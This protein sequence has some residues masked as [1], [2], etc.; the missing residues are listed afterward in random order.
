MKR[1]FMNK[2]IG[3][4]IYPTL[5]VDWEAG[6]PRIPLFIIGKLRK[7]DLATYHFFKPDIHSQTQAGNNLL[8]EPGFDTTDLLVGASR[9]GDGFI[10]PW[11]LADGGKNSQTNGEDDGWHPQLIGA[12]NCRRLFG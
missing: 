10:D 12:S 11:P 3:E 7:L 4:V 8:L 2:D 6:V 1:K 5:R 9:E